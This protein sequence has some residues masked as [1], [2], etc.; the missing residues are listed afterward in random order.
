MRRRPAEQANE[1]RRAADLDHAAEYRRNVPRRQRWVAAFAF[2]PDDPC[3]TQCDDVAT[4]TRHL[5]GREDELDFVVAL[6]DAPERLPGTRVLHGEAG[7]GKTSLWLAGLEHAAAR[8]YRVLRTRP[9]EA[10]TG[11]SYAGLTDLLGEVVGDLLPELPPIQRRALE[12]ALLLGESELVADERAIASAFL[13]ALR[14]LAR[15]EPVLVAVDDIQWMDTESL[16]SL[17]FALARLGDAPIAAL[18][19]VRGVPPEW[20]RRTLTE[21]RLQEIEVDGLSLGAT[22]ELLRTRLDA[23]FPRPTLIRIWETSRGNPFFGLELGGALQ[24]HGG[25]LDPGEELP[26]PSDLEELLHARLEGLGAAAMDV[27]HAVGVLADPTVEL[28]ESAVGRSSDAA[29]AEALA[30]R[31]LQQDGEHLRFTHPLLGSAAAARRTSSRRRSLHARLAEIVPTDEERARHIALATARPDGDIASVLEGAAAQSRARGAPAAAAELAEHALRLTPASSAEDARRRALLVADLHFRAGD[32]PRAIALLE[33]ARAVAEPGRERAAVVARL[34]DVQATPREATALYREALAEAGDDDALRADVYFKLAGLMRFTDGI[35][36][37]LEHGELAVQV[38]S[39]V[40]DAA[41]RCRA[42]AAYGLLHFNAGRGIPSATMEEALALER[43]LAEWPLDDGPAY[44][45]GHQLW[46]SGEVGRAR[47]LF[48]E[49]RDAVVA[50]NDPWGDA[51]ALWYLGLLEWRAG[52][53]EE[54]D[55]CAAGSLDLCMQLRLPMPQDQYPTAVI[56]AHRGRVDEARAVAQSAL[57]VAEAE[58]ISVGRSGH[59][60]V[61]GFVELSLGDAAAALAHLQGAHEVRDPHLLEPGMRL[62]MG[63]LLEALVTAGELDEAHE[64]LGTWEERARDLDRAWAL[65]I[66]ARSR[67]LLLAARGDFEGAFASFEQALAEHARSTDPFSH[68]RTLLA[69][70]RSQ[71]RAK[72]RGAARATLADALE[73]FER[74]G[75]PLWA[76]QA[77]AELARIGGR[78]PGTGELTE[79]EHRIAELVA[80]GRTNREVAAALFITVHSVETALTRIYRKLAVRSRSELASTYPSKT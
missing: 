62:Y 24:R 3:G 80:Q 53:W 42:A 27:V 33:R 31:V 26:I 29:L 48:R 77:R 69:L 20:L 6:F 52:N 15:D 72:H 67:G 1:C 22:N 73:R 49:F 59:G 79:A 45:Y 37:G 14:V 13:G 36:S 5:V 10:E 61:L 21:D 64:I 46:W 38:A 17:R 44:V 51:T 8:G 74:V 23:R 11:Y 47:E 55:R 75:A 18:I 50:R 2:A 40:D 19:A 25:A 12:T 57:A 63:D 7:I 4:G 65:A 71:R 35:E 16:G 66:L 39:R 76:E 32:A 78:A 68:A 28:V 41:L 60:W 58:G 54:A 9:N 70:G 30:A 56:A 43:S 34:A